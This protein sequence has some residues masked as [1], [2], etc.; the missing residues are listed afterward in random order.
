MCNVQALWGQSLFSVK[1]D[2]Y[3]QQPQKEGTPRTAGAGR[4]GR[5]GNPNPITC[6]YLWK[7][8]NEASNAR[9]HT[10]GLC[11]STVTCASTAFTIQQQKTASQLQAPAST[12]YLHH[13]MT[14][15]PFAK[16]I[17]PILP[18][19]LM[20]WF[21]VLKGKTMYRNNVQKYVTSTSARSGCCHCD[22]GTI[23]QT[24][25]FHFTSVTVLA[26]VVPAQLTE[27][28]KRE[29]STVFAL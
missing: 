27:G 23:T 19:N 20:N 14:S 18:C 7:Q 3:I 8:I 16:A 13:Q 9:E 17:P 4:T 24:R 10:E 21:S 1:A 26:S 5:H 15:S 12:L 28:G 2:I 29:E 22:A 6:G 25:A 11:W